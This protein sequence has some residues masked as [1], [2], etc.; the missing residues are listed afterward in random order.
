[1]EHPSNH[2]QSLRNAALE[3]KP[4]PPPEPWHE[5]AFIHAGGVFAGG[6]TQEE[7]VLLVSFDGYSVSTPDGAR[8][9]RDRDPSR[10]AA[11]LASDALAFPLP[12]AT[13]P[14]RVFGA[15]GGNGAWVTDDGWSVE[16]VA[17]LW[18]RQWVLLREPRTG[19]GARDYLAG[20]LRLDLQGLDQHDWLRVGFSPSGRHLL[21]VSPGGC[22]V[23][24]RA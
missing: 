17:P 19:T 7:N 10:G 6:W 15:C 1:V 11:A 20:A 2:E 4:S 9:T 24:S 3:L 16:V 18:P 14:V 23:F 21:V 13:V 22:L 8:L 12:G 5:S